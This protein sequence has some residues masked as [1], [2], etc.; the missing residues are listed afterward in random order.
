M[1]NNLS[2]ISN[3]IGTCKDLENVIS[4][5]D[6]NEFIVSIDRS[7]SIEKS[8]EFVNHT[9]NTSGCL[10]KAIM[11]Y[12]SKVVN[13]CHYYGI[14]RLPLE[15][16]TKIIKQLRRKIIEEPRSCTKR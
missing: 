6:E 10:G 16:I 9:Y 15:M 2:L 13:K 7:Y 4:D 1:L 14:E 3:C 11:L 5:Y 12:H 8:S